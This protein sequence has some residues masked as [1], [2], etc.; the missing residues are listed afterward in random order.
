MLICVDQIVDGLGSND[1]TEVIMNYMMKGGALSREKLSKKL[2]CF[3][4]DGVNVFDGS[5]IRMK[6]QIKNSWAPFSMGVHCVAH[7]TNF[8]VQSLGDFPRGTLNVNFGIYMHQT[9]IGGEG[10]GGG[11]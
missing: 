4:V 8:V 6:K 10:G 3:G 5:K 2:L 1:L 9:T 11:I 7:H